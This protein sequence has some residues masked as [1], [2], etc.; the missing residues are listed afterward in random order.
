MG[1]VIETVSIEDVFPLE[2][3]YGNSMARRDYT[4]KANKDYVKRLAESFNPETKQ[5]DEP[6]VLVRD[7]G[8]YRI[9]AGNSRVEAMRLLKVKSFAAV[10]ED[11]DEKAVVEAAWRTDTK[12]T[13]EEAERADI[14]KA[15]T[16]FGDDEYVSQV[17]GIDADRVRRIRRGS[18]RSDESVEQMTMEWMEAVGEFEDDPEAAKAILDAGASGWKWEA[19]RRRSAAARAQW[20]A[21]M[22][23]ALADAGVEVVDE[24]QGGMRY[25]SCLQ[26]PAD[27]E[28]MNIEPGAV[29]QF[30]NCNSC[31]WLYF[32]AAEGAPDPEEER[33]RALA[34]EAVAQFEEADASRS[35]WLAGHLEEIDPGTIVAAMPPGAEIDVYE[36]DVNEFCELH[37]V[38]LPMG[39]AVTIA[40]FCRLSRCPVGRWSR[41]MIADS[42]RDFTALT[43]AM[44]LCGYEPPEAEQKLYQ[45]CADAIGK[46]DGDE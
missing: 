41:E 46:E 35:A 7:E 5:P 11:G 24:N 45:K 1:R 6:P 32:P 28:D 43:D 20:R 25:E 16:L 4:L 14:F 34:D 39:P 36:Y 19:E 9:K 40:A 22:E 8:I 10:V 12:K 21:E 17:T 38:D 2:D 15:L 31:A 23:A 18:K 42:C 37:E 30:N 44:E 26:S 27:L 29:A 13:Y 3:E 33:R